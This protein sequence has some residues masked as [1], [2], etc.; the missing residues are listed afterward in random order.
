M[1]EHG[2]GHEKD[3]HEIRLTYFVNGERQ[4]SDEKERTVHEIL[5]SAGFD[6]PKDY[7]LTRDEGNHVY[8]DY[9]TEVHLHE[10]ERFTATYVGPTPTS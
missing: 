3:H 6:P 8:E 10:G 4:E 5:E 7:R 2:Q 9:G 1:E